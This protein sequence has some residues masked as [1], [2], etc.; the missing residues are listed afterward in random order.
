MLNNR[1]FVPATLISALTIRLFSLNQS[2]WLD[3]ATST[4][5]AKNFSLHDL[6]FKFAPGDFHPPLYYLLLKIWISVFGSTEVAVRAMSVLFGVATVYMVY[7]LGKRLFSEQIGQTAA[8]LATVSPLLVYY[9]QEARMYSLETFL[10]IVTVWFFVTEMWV[11]FIV[12]TTLLLYTDYL[13][14]LLILSLLAA[15]KKSLL[16]LMVVFVFL[17]PWLPVLSRQLHN[18]LA[19]RDNSPGWWLVLGR[20]NLKELLLVP[21]KFVIGRMS[22]YNKFLYTAFVL[23]SFAVFA[24]PLHHAL[25]KWAKSRLLW[26]W[27]FVPIAVAALI[28]FRVSIFSYF[29]LLFLLPAFCLL[30]AYGLS[31]VEKRYKNT[32]FVLV[33]LFSFVCTAIYLFTPRFH[34]EDWRGAVSWIEQD[35]NDKS[36]AA[37]FVTKNQRDPYFYYTQN[38]VRSYGPDG[39][40]AG[41]FERIYLMRYVQPIF[42][43][44]DTLRKR[45]EEAGYHKTTEKDFNGVTVWKYERQIYASGN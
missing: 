42:D 4:L 35:A 27:L 32:V 39:L 10:A 11:G 31:L 24:I 18:G 40:E 12:A 21:T 1:L 5:A 28:G 17:T 26:M 45:V 44:Q 37:L 33:V 41:N 25:Q 13:P 9:S 20:T 16:P 8:I 30:I 34:R 6:I 14:V 36:A 38:V 23:F 43:P 7:R 22:F 29:R 19:V 15:K 2:L 3:E